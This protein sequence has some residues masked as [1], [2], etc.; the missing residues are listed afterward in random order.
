M[1]SFF[2]FL[3]FSIQFKS[4]GNDV[5][6]PEGYPKANDELA[7]NEAE[8]TLRFNGTEIVYDPVMEVGEDIEEENGESS[9]AVATAPSMILMFAA[10]LAFIQS[11]IF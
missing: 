10:L 3:F 4:G 7:D 1:I 9:N 2:S 11:K 6:M 5:E 8:I